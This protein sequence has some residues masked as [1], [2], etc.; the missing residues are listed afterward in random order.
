MEYRLAFMDETFTERDFSESTALSVSVSEIT[1]NEYIRKIVIDITNKGEKTNL[2]PFVET[3][4]QGEITYYMIPCVNYNGNLWGTGE[5]PKGMC[6]DGKPWIFPADRVGLPGCSVV[7]SEVC[8]VGLFADNEGLSKKA[9][10]SVFTQDGKTV[11]RIYFSSIEYPYVYLRKFDYGDPLIAYVSFENGETKHF[12]CYLYQYQKS[13]EAYYGYKKL[14]DYVNGGTYFSAVNPPYSAQERKR[15]SEEFMCSL[16][17]KS[18]YGYLSNMGYLP[19]GEHRLGDERAKWCYRKQ[20]KYEIG[21]CGQN[22]TVAEM[23]LR[24]YLENAD[25]EYKERGMGILRAWLKRMHPCGLMGC[26][27]DVP[28][29]TAERIDTCNEGWFLYKLMF[30]CRLIKQ[31]G[32]SA[33]EYENAAKRICAFFIRNYPDGGFPQILRGDGNCI[34]NDGCAGVMLMLGFAQAYEYFGDAEYLARAEKAFAFYYDTYLSKS[35]AAGGALDTYC[36]DKESAGP[37]LRTALK[38]YAFTG[39]ETYFACAE[40]IA[41]YLMTWCFYH[42]VEFDPDSDCARLGLRTT[43]GTSVSAAHHH[44]DC[45]GAFYVPDF[46]ELYEK[47]KNIAYRNHAEALW[48]FTLQYMSDGNL[49]LHGMVRRRGAQN[50]AVIQCNWH[51]LDEERGQLND[52]MVAWVKT[53]QLD[54]IYAFQDRGYGSVLA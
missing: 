35:V 17:E 27:Y 50:E 4:M 48:N 9:S 38:L 37:V 32:E 13:G 39:K 3:A 1:Q 24:L 18:E 19:N 7:E 26:N 23:Y 41:H 49:R 28:F 10:A 29:N 2:I 54:V 11:Q 53:F 15:W 6:K 20:N 16:T 22:I 44:I 14:F 31:I 25:P 40:N 51:Q 47:T 45:W 43:G 34:V 12:V 33:E 46:Y 42:D 8:C 21:W 5:E 30:C 36:I 52:W